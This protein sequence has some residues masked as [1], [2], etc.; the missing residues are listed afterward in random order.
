MSRKPVFLNSSDLPIGDATTWLDVADIVSKRVGSIS[1]E[2]MQRHA[3]E[4]PGGF[5]VMLRLQPMD[6]QKRRARNA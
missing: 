3:H 1:A 6:S 2:K 5:Y 4:G